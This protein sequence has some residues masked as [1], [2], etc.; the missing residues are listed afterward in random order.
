MFYLAWEPLLPGLYFHLL[1]LSLSLPL[2]MCSYSP[3]PAR[4]PLRSVRPAHTHP[5][6]LIRESSSNSSFPS[7]ITF[8]LVGFCR[9]TPS[10]SSLSF[11]LPQPLSRSPS[12]SH[13]AFPSSSLLFQHAQPPLSLHTPDSVVP[14]YSLTVFLPDVCFPSRSLS[15]TG[16]SD[17]PDPI[18]EL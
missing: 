5:L 7:T 10:S 13:P 17:G 2:Y 14:T 9:L 8:L 6:S 11:S 3:T 12:L 1:T 18:P 16:A 4:N 15:T